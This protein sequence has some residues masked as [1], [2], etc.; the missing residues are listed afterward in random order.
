MKW[1]SLKSNNSVI[2]LN[3]Y[4]LFVVHDGH[5]IVRN[6]V[7]CTTAAFVE[8][9]LEAWQYVSTKILNF[10]RILFF[11]LGI[12]LVGVLTNDWMNVRILS[13]SCALLTPVSE[14]W[15]RYC[16]HSGLSVHGGNGSPSPSN[17]TSTGSMSFQGVPHP[18]ILPLVPCPFQGREY[19]QEGYPSPRW[20]T[21]SPRWK[22]Q[23]RMWY[24]P[25]HHR[26]WYPPDRTAEW[27]LFTRRAVCL[28]SA[29]RR[30]LLL[31]V[32]EHLCVLHKRVAGYNNIF[33][34]Y[35]LSLNSSTVKNYVLQ[36]PPV[37]IWCKGVL[38]YTCLLAMQ[39]YGKILTKQN[40]GYQC[41]PIVGC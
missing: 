15:G 18:T 20:E 40:L 19:P 38:T 9:T 41:K 33:Y 25:S 17:N 8:V 2:R 26:M 28:L 36:N 1:E 27:V 11:M 29:C 14:G 31:V 13:V 24:P 7:G 30:I 5:I 12:S 4:S 23:D 35:F 37:G 32:W 21:P 10:Q 39:N 22:V 16:F 34:N 3:T 6:V